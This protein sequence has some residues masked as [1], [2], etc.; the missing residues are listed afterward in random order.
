MSRQNIA[1]TAKRSNSTVLDQLARVE[2]A[3][4]PWWAKAPSIAAGCV[5]LALFPVQIIAIT[6]NAI[7][8]LVFVGI[9]GVGVLWWFGFISDAA[10]SGFLGKLGERTLGIV[11]SSGLI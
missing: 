1:P 4:T 10:V 9:I 2:A 3:S 11:R 6:A 8:S 5:K 7:V